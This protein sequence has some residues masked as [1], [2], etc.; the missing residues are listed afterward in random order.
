MRNSIFSLP[1][2]F[3][4][5]PEQI[6]PPSRAHVATLDVASLYDRLDLDEFSV[7]L[8]HGGRPAQVFDLSQVNARSKRQVA[9]LALGIVVREP[10]RLDCR[11]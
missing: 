11:P 1:L 3:V 9:G 10:R 6:G 4:D 8:L 2:L 5:L 7:A